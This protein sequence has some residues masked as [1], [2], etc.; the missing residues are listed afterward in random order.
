MLKD[1]RKVDEVCDRLLTEFSLVDVAKVR[2]GNLSGGQ[3]KK[4]SIARALIADPEIVLLDEI[5]A[6]LSPKVIETI[7]NLIARLQTSRKSLSILISDHIWQ[8][9]NDLSDIVHILSNGE[10]IK[11]KKPAD[12]IKDE[13][14][15]EAYFGDI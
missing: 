8:H 6:A 3:K 7:K 10:I 5:F 9:V 4:L 12:I 11:S 1:S 2:A 14:A 13:S 15:R